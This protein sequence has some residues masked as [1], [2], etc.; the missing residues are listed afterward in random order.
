[1]LV[2]R[3]HAE[4][5]AESSKPLVSAFD[6][7]QD[8]KQSLCTSMAKATHVRAHCLREDE[9]KARWARAV[10]EHLAG[11][12]FEEEDLEARRSAPALTRSG[13]REP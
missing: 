13:Q 6:E 10:G 7:V 9:R 1:M 5:G 4:R 2:R 8:P 3:L 12:R 11:M